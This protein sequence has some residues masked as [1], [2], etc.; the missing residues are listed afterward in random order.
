MHAHQASVWVATRLGSS[1][2]YRERAPAAGRSR[3]QAPPAGAAPRWPRSRRSPARCGCP[4]GSAPARRRP[5]MSA[6]QS[7]EAPRATIPHARCYWHAQ[8]QSAAM[9]DVK[10]LV[11]RASGCTD[12][13]T[14][15]KQTGLS[16]CDVQKKVCLPCGTRESMT[17]QERRDNLQCTECKGN[18]PSVRMEP[19][20]CARLEVLAA[21]HG[22]EGGG[23]DEVRAAFHDELLQG[24]SH[25]AQDTRQPEPA[26]HR[27]CTAR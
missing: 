1:K 12:R 26:A 4:S 5:G 2:S 24:E 19:G 16:F 11:Q 13:H 7:S 22:A 15:H 21:A 14:S 20:A 25:R 9:S 17:R 6:T 8:Q 23:G 3:A 10:L 18:P 27:A